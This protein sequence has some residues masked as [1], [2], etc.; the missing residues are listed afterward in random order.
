MWM[1][2]MRTYME[3]AARVDKGGVQAFSVI[4]EGV[5]RGGVVHVPA[6]PSR[7]PLVELSSFH[8]TT[9]FSLRSGVKISHSM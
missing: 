7:Y 8:A 4:H 5:T 3:H 6:T 2:C 1:R 9:T